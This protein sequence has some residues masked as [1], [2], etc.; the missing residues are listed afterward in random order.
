VWSDCDIGCVGDRLT[1]V[2]SAGEKNRSASLYLT[3]S[4]LH[5]LLMKEDQGMLMAVFYRQFKVSCIFNKY[6]FS[7]LNGWQMEI[8]QILKVL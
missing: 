1:G 3:P 4:L 8:S 6:F 5:Q 7:F 2:I